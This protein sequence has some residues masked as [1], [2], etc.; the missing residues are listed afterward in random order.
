MRFTHLYA[1]PKPQ[2]PK[3]PNMSSIDK[4][5]ELLKGPEMTTTTSFFRFNPALRNTALV[6]LVALVSA[7]SL[8]V[9]AQ[10]MGMAGGAGMHGGAVGH[11]GHGGPGRGMMGMSERMLDAVKATPD[12]RAQIKQ[13]MDAARKDMQSQHDAR[14]ALQGEAAKLFA[15]PNVDA[16]AV[17]ALRQ[18]QMAQHDQASKRMM[19]AM[20]DASRV[21]TPD[22]R[23]QLADRMQQRHQMMER[24]M[25]E[26][27]TLDAPKS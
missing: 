3:T 17:E 23:K 11:G 20:L 26:R 7:A 21:L 24:H 13:I 10:P 16:N 22:Q 1:P 2:I 8:P 14:K 6:V 5:A 27:Q 15:Q 25:K 9:M 12:Q 19:Q 4:P 18:K